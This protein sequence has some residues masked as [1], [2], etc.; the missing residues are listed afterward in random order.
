MRV[1]NFGF[2]SSSS[3]VLKN[4]SYI[5]VRVRVYKNL[6][7]RVRFLTHSNFPTN[8]SIDFRHI[9]FRV[10]LALATGY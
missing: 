7:E 5:R 6:G 3:R 9:E 4:D 2:E 8:V 10:V 1:C